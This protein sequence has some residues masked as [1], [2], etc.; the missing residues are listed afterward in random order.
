MRRGSRIETWRFRTGDGT[1]IDVELRLHEGKLLAYNG[2]Y[3][4]VIYD[5][6]IVSLKNKAK[7]MAENS[8]KLTW[9]PKIL[10]SVALQ[11]HSDQHDKMEVVELTLRIEKWDIAK[12]GGGFCHRRHKGRAGDTV[13]DGLPASR[14][15][16]Y[17]T[18]AD[19]MLDDD[20]AL[21]S[22]TICQHFK[23]VLKNAA[24][25]LQDAVT[26]KELKKTL[27]ALRDEKLHLAL[28]VQ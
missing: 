15:S 9:T 25:A 19:F 27:A 11:S 16:D 8:G 24:Y 21:D 13:W 26:G 17:D 14:S 6:D 22:A 4:I 12:R 28:R 1:L 2:Q 10:V 7:D 3:N 5:T 18:V 20:A 23:A